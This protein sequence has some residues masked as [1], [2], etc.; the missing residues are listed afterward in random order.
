MGQGD[1][2][3]HRCEALLHGFST[4]TRVFALARYL[5]VTGW[6]GSVAKLAVLPPLSSQVSATASAHQTSSDRESPRGGH[7]DMSKE[8]I[9]TGPARA[10]RWADEPLNALLLTLAGTGLAA[11]LTIAS[12]LL[13][14]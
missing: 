6:A 2:L 11:T 8:T 14:L 3:V 5:L 7:R 10:A 9:Q 4:K 12:A 1:L 13:T